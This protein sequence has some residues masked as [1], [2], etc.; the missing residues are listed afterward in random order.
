MSK[1]SWSDQ[2]LSYSE[3]FLKLA[4][5]TFVYTFVPASGLKSVQEKGLL[6]AAKLIQDPEALEAAKPKASGKFVKD[7][8]EKLADPEWTSIVQGVSAFFTLPDWNKLEKNHFI[9]KNQLVPIRINVSKLIR[10]FPKTK[11]F[12]LEMIPSTAPEAQQKYRERALTL[13]EVDRWASKSPSMVWQHYDNPK[14]DK[15]APDVP[16]LIILTP[17]QTIPPG[18]L[19]L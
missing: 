6:S 4:E 8:T 9:F 5:E 17:S 15:Y 2:L 3:N 16:H 1:L 12:G 18:C 13:K 19:D 10:R 7:I 14:N 11:F